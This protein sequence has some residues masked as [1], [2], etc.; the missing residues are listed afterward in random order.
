MTSIIVLYRIFIALEGEN[1]SPLREDLAEHA[2]LQSQYLSW[3]KHKK[4]ASFRSSQAL[5]LMKHAM[6]LSP[7]I[8]SVV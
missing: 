8:P 7:L 5:G 2:H 6:W 4:G 3:K 1:S